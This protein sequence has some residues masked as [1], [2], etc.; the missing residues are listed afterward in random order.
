[1]ELQLTRWKSSRAFVVKGEG[2]MK[3]ISR[4][5]FKENDVVEIWAFKQRAFRYF[6]V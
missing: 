3:F 6:G 5:G 4:C 2:Y 1:M